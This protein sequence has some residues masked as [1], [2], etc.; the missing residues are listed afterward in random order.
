VIP[1]PRRYPV[2]PLTG[3]STCGR[4]T[5]HRSTQYL[6]RLYGV[7]DEASDIVAKPIRYR[8]AQFFSKPPN[9][10]REAHLTGLRVICPP[11]YPHKL[12][13]VNA[14]CRRSW[15]L[16]EF[17]RQQSPGPSEGRPGDDRGG[18]EGGRWRRAINPIA[19]SVV[20]VGIRVLCGSLTHCNCS[21]GAIA[22]TAA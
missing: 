4:T 6:T 20:F 22:A 9:A 8:A 17:P 3:S 11:T 12:G 5:T 10:R 2:S 7:P 1:H 13:T 15:L 19:R 18:D 16:S 21:P 14:Q